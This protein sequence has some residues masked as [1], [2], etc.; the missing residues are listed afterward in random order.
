VVEDRDGV[1]TLVIKTRLGIDQNS[2]ASDA[3]LQDLAAPTT[4]HSTIVVAGGTGVIE[5]DQDATAATIE[6][7]LHAGGTGNARPPSWRQM[8]NGVFS[9]TDRGFAERISTAGFDRADVNLSGTDGIVARLL[10][11]P[12]ILESTT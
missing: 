12:A 7:M 5:Y 6:V 4:T 9:V 3:Q 1:S 8:N 11:G 2:Q 10:L